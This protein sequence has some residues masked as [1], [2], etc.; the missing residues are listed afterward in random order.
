MG[1]SIE[2]EI[3][4]EQWLEAVES[5]EHV[6]ISSCDIRGNVRFTRATIRRTTPKYVILARV[7][8]DG[9]QTDGRKFLKVNG[10]E[11][12]NSSSKL[13][14]IDEE[15]KRSWHRGRL[16]QRIDNACGE[17][18]SMRVDLHKL[19]DERLKQLDELLTVATAEGKCSVAM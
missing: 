2:K 11:V 9:S 3:T 18:S 8:A 16:M 4:R 6:A 1:T 10:T 7:E 5:G 19:S 13:H 15:V 17:I 12:G 14:R